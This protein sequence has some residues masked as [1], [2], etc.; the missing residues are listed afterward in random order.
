MTRRALLVALVIAAA[1]G[2]LFGLY[3]D[4][5]LRVAAL[6]YSGSDF[7]LVRSPVLRVLREAN[8]LVI[9]LLLAPVLFALVRKLVR[10]NRPLA[11][12]GRAI[13][14]L[15]ATILFG[16][17]LFTNI[18]LKDHW[19]RP[20]PRDIAVFGGTQHF[21]AWWDPRGDCPGNC[22]FV[23]G[24]PTGAFWTLAPASL[25]PPQ[26]RAAAY[27]GALAFGTGIGLLRMSFG[28]H[29]FS[30]VVFAGVLS[31]LVVFVAH[32][33]IYR[34]PATRFSDAAVERALESI[35]HRLRA[36]WPRRQTRD[37]L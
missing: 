3:P 12:S 20:R 34:W 1:V 9:G 2:V 16:P 24:E 21:V 35:A 4:L 33:F 30:D 36:L 17:L 32:G 5:D 22:S 18:I 6:F 31:F 13:V 11:I 19:G 27:A 25:A 10:P 26:W 28:G 14:Y 7:A 29:F 15:L 8:T 23:A 37:K